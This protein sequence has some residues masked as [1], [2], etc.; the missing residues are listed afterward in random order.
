[1]IHLKGILIPVNWDKKGNIVA[2]AIATE[3]EEEYWIETKGRWES[4]MKHLREEVEVR[5]V[6][7]PGNRGKR[8]EFVELI[9]PSGI[10][11]GHPDCN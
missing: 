7:K 6:L 11:S 1:M 9:K 5:G 4:L 8:I 2:L 10:F 3:N